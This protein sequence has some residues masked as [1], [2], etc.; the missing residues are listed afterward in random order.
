MLPAQIQRQ[1]VKVLSVSSQ[2]AAQSILISVEFFWT[3]MYPEISVVKKF[4]DLLQIELLK[5][6]AEF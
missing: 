2:N 1:I 4:G 6:L 3:H 5:I